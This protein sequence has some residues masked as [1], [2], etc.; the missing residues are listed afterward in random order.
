MRNTIKAI[1]EKN[2]IELNKVLDVYEGGGMMFQHA[3]GVMLGK[4]DLLDNKTTYAVCRKLGRSQLELELFQSNHMGITK[5]IGKKAAYATGN[6]KA[7]A[8]I[9]DI[10]GLDIYLY[11]N[12]NKRGGKFLACRVHANAGDFSLCKLDVVAYNT[13]SVDDLLQVNKGTLAGLST[14]Q[15]ENL[16]EYADVHFFND[17]MGLVSEPLHFE[18]EEAQHLAD[19]Y[20]FDLYQESQA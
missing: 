3:D 5:S 12:T 8:I 16:E 13:L 4:V 2:V 1:N 20:Q 18:A 11:L 14:Q 7:L 9:S 6:G 15:R 10:L 19:L 17:N